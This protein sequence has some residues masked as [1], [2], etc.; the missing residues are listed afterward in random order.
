MN[1]ITYK[2][3]FLIIKQKEKEILVV[4]DLHLGF[5]SALNQAGIFINRYIFEEVEK[6]F[7]ELFEFKDKF[8]EIV[9]LGD[10]KHTF[11]SILK[12]ERQQF[13]KIIEKLE[14]RT[15]K[16]IITKGNHDVLIN[17]LPKKDNLEI[18]DYYLSEEI[19]FLHG[20][21]DFDLIKDKKI[22]TI[23]IGHLHPAIV[24]RDGVKSEK[25]KC[26]LEGKYKD[27][28]FIICPSFISSNEGTDPRD[29]LTKLPWPLELEEF[30]VIAVGNELEN[31]E[32]G[33][34]KEIN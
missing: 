16:L 30:K 12:E 23:V 7:D 11:G 32:F 14:K 25:Y 6:S 26:F 1:K 31:F 4:G 9:L 27:K 33:K 18:K 19:A 13:E 3:K 2:G 28:N 10:I 34:L 20:D 8:N 15:E 21:R 24:L 17:Y 29:Y 22:K 5:E